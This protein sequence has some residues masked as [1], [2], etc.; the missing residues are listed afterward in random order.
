[1][2]FPGTGVSKGHGFS[3]RK[4]PQ[5]TVSLAFT[6]ACAVQRFLQTWYSAASLID[7]LCP[8]KLLVVSRPGHTV[9]TQLIDD[10]VIILVDYCIE[11]HIVIVATSSAHTAFFLSC[12]YVVLC[13]II[14]YILLYIIFQTLYRIYEE[15]F[16]VYCVFCRCGAYIMR[17]TLS[18]LGPMR[19]LDKSSPW[20]I[21]Q[22]IVVT[23]MISCVI[24]SRVIIFPFSVD[25]YHID[26]YS[27]V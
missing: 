25:K 12:E 10:C 2:F 13:S 17:M 1:M 26:L 24:P 21:C 7:P 8:W 6:H 23:A 27:Y 5:L 9:W 4:A 19:R 14:Y 16:F 11:I 3:R 18:V 20:F 22:K 15:K